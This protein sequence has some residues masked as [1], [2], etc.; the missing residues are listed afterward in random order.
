MNK[1]NKRQQLI[2]KLVQMLLAHNDTRQAV[3]LAQM[4]V[5]QET[6][7]LCI[8]YC[9]TRGLLSDVSDLVKLRQDKPQFTQAEIDQ[10]FVAQLSS[11]GYCNL[12]SIEVDLEAVGWPSREVIDLLVA[13]CLKQDNLEEAKI[14]TALREDNPQFTPD[15]IKSILA[16]LIAK[17]DVG[18]AQEIVRLR[19]EAPELTP[20]EYEAMA[21]YAIK[22]CFMM[23]GIHRIFSRV[24]SE[25]LGEAIACAV[26]G[27][28]PMT[29][30]ELVK[31][32]LNQP[33]LTSDEWSQIVEA[34]KRGSSLQCLLQ[35]F[36]DLNDENDEVD[37]KTICDCIRKLVRKGKDFYLCSDSR[38]NEE[39]YD[40]L[41]P[42]MKDC[43]V[44]ANI[45]SGALFEATSRAYSGCLPKTVDKLIEA[46]IKAGDLD[47][48]FN[49]LRLRQNEPQLTDDE[50]KR[51]IP[52]YS[53][54]LRK[55]KPVTDEIE[56]EEYEE[57][58]DDDDD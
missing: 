35:D 21:D 20:A 5:D 53:E 12:N 51:L 46:C 40:K 38:E 1:P 34:T 28:N 45:N 37:E 54:F 32:R 47:N 8:D 30:K 58:D 52:A 11:N 55:P 2:A 7:N 15:E 3:E 6:I 14:F 18:R 24:S 22:V 43:Y 56:L 48:L 31:Y 19:L 36:L 41:T 16:G 26:K 49:S 33:K 23:N 29:A 17:G 10:A 13:T 57:Y 4:G 44:D 9:V 25:K 50:L 42:A 39:Y 27:A